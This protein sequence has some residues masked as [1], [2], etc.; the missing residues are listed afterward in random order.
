MFPKAGLKLAGEMDGLHCKA[1]GC[2]VEVHFTAELPHG[3][4]LISGVLHVMVILTHDQ[5]NH[6]CINGT[7]LTTR[8]MHS[9]RS[10]AIHPC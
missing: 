3:F 6:G 10:R 5:T 4:T 1:V 7:P 2:F 9:Y 8:S